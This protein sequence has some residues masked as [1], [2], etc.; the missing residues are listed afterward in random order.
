MFP[1]EV[2][3]RRTWCLRTLGPIGSS[4]SYLANFHLFLCC[5]NSRCLNMHGSS[6]YATNL[7]STNGHSS[8]MPDH[9]PGRMSR[10]SCLCCTAFHLQCCLCMN[11]MSA[12]NHWIHWEC[13]N[14]CIQRTQLHRRFLSSRTEVSLFLTKSAG[15]E[16]LGQAKNYHWHFQ[17]LKFQN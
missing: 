14:Y 1:F 10:I 7:L 17:S 11:Q 2:S 4:S 9:Y 15:E 16:L 6:R 5:Y 3:S 13:W 12:C 8:M